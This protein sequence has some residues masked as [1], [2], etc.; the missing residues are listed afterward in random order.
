M[1]SFFSR[2]RDPVDSYTHFIEMCIRDREKIGFE[3]DHFVKVRGDRPQ[4]PQQA[5]L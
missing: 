5:E 1:P 2:A 4:G 3:R